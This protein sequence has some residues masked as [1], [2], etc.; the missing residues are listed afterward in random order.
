MLRHSVQA[1]PL[2]APFLSPALPWP[3]S[4]VLTPP[5][6]LPLWSGVALCLEARSS[7]GSGFALLWPAGSPGSRAGLKEGGGGEGRKL[8]RQ[9]PAGRLPVPSDLGVRHGPALACRRRGRACGPLFPGLRV[10][11]GG[12][13]GGGL[14]RS[15]GTKDNFVKPNLIK[16]QTTSKTSL[17]SMNVRPP[18]HAF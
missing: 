6:S 2:P 12:V 14:G 1:S 10:R 5:G 4:K 7:E 9:G 8:G 17:K 15:P 13:R 16:E 11:G 3:P 18:P